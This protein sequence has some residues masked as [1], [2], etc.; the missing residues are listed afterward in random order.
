[1]KATKARRKHKPFTG[2]ILKNRETVHPLATLRKHILG[3]PHYQT[4]W[5]W[6]IRGRVHPDHPKRRIKLEAIEGTS[7][8]ASSVEAYWRFL[9]RINEG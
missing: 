2:E 7:G 8:L 9:E 6:C 4:L 3:E 1:M 5:M